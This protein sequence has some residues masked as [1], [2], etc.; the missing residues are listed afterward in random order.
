VVE[1]AQG[2]AGPYAGKLLADFGAD[3]VKVE[4]PGG[5]RARGLGPFPDD[6]PD[7]EQSAIFLHL[8]TNKRSVVASPDDPLVDGLVAGADVV[9]QSAPV[10]DPAELRARHPRLVVATVTSFGLTGPLAGSVGEEIVHY[11]YGGP[12][13]ATG[14][15]EREPLKMGGAIGQYQCGSVAAVAVLAALAVAE[16]SGDG[17]HIDLSNVETQVCSIDRRMTYLLYGAYRGQNVERIGG[18]RVSPLPSGCRP[19]MDGHIQISTLMNWIPRMLAVVDEPDLAEVY[20]DP[21]FLV[22]EAAP[23]IVD[24]HLMA[25]SLTRTKQEAMEQAQAGNWPVT[26]VN[27]PVDLLTDRHFTERRFFVPVDHPVAGTVPQPGAPIRMEDGWSLRR[28]APLLGQHTDEVAAEVA[29][30]GGVDEP[31][32]G[33]GPAP[34]APAP[35]SAGVARRLPLE[36]VRVLDMTVVWAGPYATWMLAD[37]GAEVI[38]VDNPWIF[39]SATRGVL[40]R[41]TR[42]MVADLGGI[43]GGY[44]DAD[45]GDRPWNRVALFNAHARNKRSV[46][47]DLRKEEGRETLLRL[48]ERCD[49]M[50]ENNSVDLIDKLGIGWDVL[51]R[52]NPRLNLIRM[53][54]VGLAGPYRDYLGFGVNFEG[55]CGL[56]SVRGYRGE[57]L[58]EGETVFHMD[59]AS[60]A[61]GAL[62]ALMALRRTGRTGVGEMIEL[63]QSEN[64]MNHIGE[65]LIDA[66]RTGRVHEPMGNRHHLFAPQG[67]YRCQ[68]DDAWAVLCV[69]DDAHWRALADLLDRPDL[70]DD[71]RFATAEARRANHDELDELIGAWT[72]RQTPDQVFRRCQQR[73]IAAAPVLHELEALAD[74]H[75]QARHMFAETGSDDL[76]D[77]LYPT[78]LWQWDG[79]ELAWGRLPVLGGDNEAVLKGVAGLSDDD[80]ADLEANGHL[81]G[82]YLDPDG[83]PL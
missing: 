24:G 32:G 53:P 50:V 10:P 8:N 64:M 17:V 43:F 39:P 79:P 63:S 28:P 81:A 11:A 3:V 15:P 65:L 19:T 54:S 61:A 26:A 31:S 7:P 69:T 60:G 30:A 77:H 58:S 74:P 57:D 33:A 42:E 1:L 20:Q 51:H 73:G 37:L 49:L 27:R 14:A 38:R 16:A 29:D 62:A 4:P 67:C 55:L 48:A 46:T 41:P 25:W 78:H 76:G 2:I 9:L 82:D 18:Y 12:M 6:L 35:S 70:A 44:P 71:V 68:G 52:R 72:A 21:G 23:E 66:A 59:A 83:N 56:T 80:Y 34:S 22:D 36:G 75:L 5:D 45:P 47:L 40:A 13:S